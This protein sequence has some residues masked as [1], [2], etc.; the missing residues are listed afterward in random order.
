M[1]DNLEKSNSERVGPLTPLHVVLMDIW[2]KVLQIGELGPDDDFFEVGGHSLAAIQLVNE[3][4]Q[5]FQC[6]YSVST[7]FNNSTIAGMAENLSKDMVMDKF[8]CGN[9]YSG[10]I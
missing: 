9:I 1:G 6:D 2:K 5:R 7:F 8:L 10:Q 3:V 4:R